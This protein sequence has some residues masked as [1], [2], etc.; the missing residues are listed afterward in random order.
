MTGD[1]F[2]RM[3]GAGQNSVDGIP[4]IETERLRLRGHSLSDFPAMVALW[5]DVD[6]TRFVG[7]RAFTAE[8]CWARYLRYAGHWCCLGYGY[9]AVEEKATN[10]FVGE[11]G[12][13]D[14]KRETTPPFSLAPE[15]GWVLRSASHGRGYATEI[16]RALLVWGTGYFGTEPMHCIIDEGHHASLHVARK[17]GFVQRGR[18]VYRGQSMILLDWRTE[19]SKPVPGP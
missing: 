7:G 5:G 13:A 10:T 9:W 15:V 3:H 2:R 6:V 17:C 8:E 16:V 1:T 14:Y 19:P 11:A 18:L 4:V 12:F